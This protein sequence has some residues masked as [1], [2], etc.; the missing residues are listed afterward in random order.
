MSKVLRYASPVLFL[1]VA[2]CGG[3]PTPPADTPAPKAT[4]TT[5]PPEPTAS[6]KA[7]DTPDAAAPEPPAKPKP[8]AG[9][10]VP[11]Y[12]GATEPQ[13]IGT[14][15]A[16]FRIDDGAELR[17]PT[18]WFN[19][20]RN[21]LMAVDK[22]GKGTTGKLGA[23]Y[24]IHVQMPDTQF[25]MGEESPSDSITSQAD[26]FVIKLPLPKG[27]ESASIA[28]ESIA[29]DAKTKRNK[30]TWTVMAQTKVETAD[31][32]NKAVFELRTLPDGHV[33]LTTQ[34]PSAAPAP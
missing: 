26:P 18:G 30:S 24:E 27:T 14:I 2:A 15:G 29:L 25:R 9:G 23:V 28:I 16:V 12:S 6:A 32:G 34:A 1:V 22:K 33:H 31:T 3:G 10:V 13:T 5:P 7:T 8:A 20:S 19:A 21:I 11:I 4:A 17:I